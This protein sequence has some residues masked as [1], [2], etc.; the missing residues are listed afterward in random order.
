MTLS[1]G[2]FLVLHLFFDLF[3]LLVISKCKKKFANNSR[4]FSPDIFVHLNVT[5]P[6]RR[7]EQGSWARVD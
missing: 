3:S 1:S 2:S 5:V 6:P 7:L 4:I